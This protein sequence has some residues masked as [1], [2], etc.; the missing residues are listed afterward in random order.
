MGHRLF[1]LALMAGIP[2]A[3]ATCESLATL[4]RPNTTITTA[5][6]VTGGSFKPPMG[7]AM[8]NLP[9]FCRVAGV[10]KPASDSEIMF[11]VWLPSSGWN[12]KFYG[13]G[14]GGFAGSIAFPGLAPALR[15]GF[16]TAATD[17]GHEAG[18]T[19]AKWALGHHE[20]V[21][22]FGY[23]AVHETAETAKAVIA[24][25][26]G[27]G[28]KKSYFSSCSNGGREALMEAQRYPAD[29]DGIVAGAPA[30]NWTH[31]IS[32]G[33]WESQALVSDTANYIPASK[34]PALEAA[35]LSACDANDGVK[36]G[37]IEN[38]AAC[39]FD[40][41]VLLCKG[42]ESN[43]CLTEAQLGT[44]KKIYTGPQDSKGKPM[45]IGYSPGGEPGP[46]GWGGWIS[47]GGA[48]K[49]LQ[50]AFGTNFFKYMVFDNPDWDINTFSVE[51]D[52]KVADDKV[53]QILNAT[54]ANLKKFKDRGGK[55]IVYHGWS[56]AAIPP[57]NAIEYY[58][59]VVAKMGAKQTDQ[60]VRLFMVPGMQHCGGG[61][62]PNSFGQ[63]S[64]VDS[65]AQHDINRA[66]EQWVENGV[67][68]AQI[69]ATKYK[70]AN[71]ASGVERTRPLCPY[72]QVAQWKGSGSTDDAAN[73]TCAA[74]AG[75]ASGKRSAE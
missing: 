74:G 3:A 7:P 58:R 41:S 31:L 12:G 53:G 35:A 71:P 27:D 64:E 23:R 69:I 15:R 51:H 4:G 30:N 13:V 24:A 62:G 54:D 46:N 8:E 39:H 60:F 57:T 21:V 36:D 32:S 28:P 59:S 34:L 65:D 43:S 47:G 70:T 10:I 61:P 42:D 48:G 72:P 9:A 29:Y 37:V 25:F 44:L 50:Y 66:V 56:D 67:A 17:T 18:V 52:M 1:M 5:E 63:T 33:T 55:L 45:Y 2:A 11:E 40:P 26:Y 20:K 19:D 38:P 68:P 75:G 6:S 73:F 14:N 49:S 22:D 16:A